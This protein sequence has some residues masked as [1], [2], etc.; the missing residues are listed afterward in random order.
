MKRD[1]YSWWKHRLISASQY[2][3]A[4]RLD[5]ILGFFRIWAVPETDTTAYLGHAEPYV[6]ITK[7][8]LHNAGFDD[9]RINW[10]SKPH[11]PTYSVEEI[12][13]NH[14]STIA[15]LSK[16]C[17]RIGNEELWIFKKK[18]HGI[19]SILKECPEELQEFFCNKWNDRCL[20]EVKKDTYVPSWCYGN[21]SSWKSLYP[22]EQD[23]LCHLFADNRNKQEVLWQDHAFDIL[24][25]LTKSVPMQPCGEDL[26]VSLSG[27]PKVLNDTG[28][29]GLRVVRWNRIWEEPGQPFIPFENYTPLSLTTTSVHDSTTIRQWWNNEKD[30]VIHFIAAFDADVKTTQNV[31]GI[32]KQ[33]TQIANT[34]F[35][36]QV[37][38]K[39]LMCSA[40]TASVWYVNPLQDYLFMEK[41]YWRKHE[42]DERIN[43]PGTV[44]EFNW[45]Y[46]LPATIESIL[47][48]N[49]L[50]DNMRDIVK[51]HDQRGE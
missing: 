31:E 2:Y 18:I 7:E 34:S 37:A 38:K 46:R 26:G 32:Y 42:E 45:T 30:G 48:N 6:G 41:K 8:V 27:V 23:T 4:Y 39:I 28:I 13:H 29:L 12:T 20:I 1:G 10:L 14:D 24:S 16:L 36:P 40:H 35:T 15:I 25:K 22:N 33:A 5:H 47:K 19:Q 50:I 44:T 51:C 9:G 21:T 11:I 49:K 17:D 43:I 3:G